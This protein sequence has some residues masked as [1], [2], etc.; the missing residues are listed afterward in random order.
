MNNKYFDILISYF[1][2]GINVVIAQV[3]SI[4]GSLFFLWVGLKIIKKITHFL[5]KKI[6][7]FD[8]DQSLKPYIL[9]TFSLCLKIL[10]FIS[11]AGIAG[12]ETTSFITALGAAG[13]AIG[14]ALQGSLSNFAGSFLILFFRPFNVG[15]VVACQGHQGT[16]TEISFFMTQ[17]LTFDNKTIY[18]PN[19]QIVSGPIINL[20][21]EKFRRLDLT[22]G[23]DY[24]DSIE[25]ARTVIISVL[26][27]N[28]PQNA[29]SPTPEVVVSSLGDSSVNLTLQV[30][31]ESLK[32]TDYAGLLNE[33]IKV[34]FD[35]NKISIPFPQRV[36]HQYKDLN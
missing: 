14:L 26:N 9:Q 31:V 19:G 5:N 12:I 34:A 36:F 30:W 15:D 16:V 35:S 13:I 28:I 4:M 22:F 24:K 8:L 32:L 11:V 20:T 2:T 18:I 21:R 3:P 7:H 27:D 23:I 17:F 25:K 6:L 10:L 1:T 33:K 29:M